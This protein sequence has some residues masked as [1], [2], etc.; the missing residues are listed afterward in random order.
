MNIQQ[1]IINDTINRTSDLGIE[2]FKAFITSDEMN[3]YEQAC[4]QDIIIAALEAPFADRHKP[5]NAL[6]CRAVEW[7]SERLEELNK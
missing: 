1:I 6:V 2:A 5:F 3:P 4:L 7:Q